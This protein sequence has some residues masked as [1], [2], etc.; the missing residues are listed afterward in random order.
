MA[1]VDLS[2]RSGLD[3]GSRRGHVMELSGRQPRR[4]APTSARASPLVLD[5]S[6]HFDD[7]TLYQWLQISSLTLFEKTPSGI[8]ASDVRL[9]NEDTPPANQSESFD[10]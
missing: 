6:E 4:A 10:L 5:G 8:V 3:H 7:V 9:Q 2:T 1:Q